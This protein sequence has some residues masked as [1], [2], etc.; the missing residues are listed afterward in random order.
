MYAGEKWEHEKAIM[1]MMS[2]VLLLLL[3]KLNHHVLYVQKNNECS[4]DR[5]LIS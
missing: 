3:N 4:R 5:S 2:L 1:M